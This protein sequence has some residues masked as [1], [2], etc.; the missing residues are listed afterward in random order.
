MRVSGAVRVLVLVA[1]F[2]VAMVGMARADYYRYT[3]RS[4]AVVLTNDLGSVPKAYRK[5]MKVIRD[6]ALE[7]KDPAPKKHSAAEEAIKE[8]QQD[9]QAAAAAA[10]A[11]RSDKLFARFPWAKP[12][13]I[14]AG[15]IAVLFVG[16]RLVAAI[17]FP[18]LARVINIALFL[19]VFVFVYT[20]Y[21][22]Y[23][24]DEYFSVK[25]K[26]IAMFKKA[27]QRELPADGEAPP[28]KPDGS[29]K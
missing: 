16:R 12:L 23:L 24:V 10:T 4:G 25:D 19:G 28:E 6:E 27:N 2:G 22:R 15:V 7:A 8:E 5:K 13:A 29:E 18:Q 1:V 3:D 26:V 14:V 9:E 21:A 11:S 17:P 20:V